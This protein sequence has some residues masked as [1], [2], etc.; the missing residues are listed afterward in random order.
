MKVK[1]LFVATAIAA[2]ISTSAFA[3]PS[4]G[5]GNLGSLPPSASFANTVAGAFTDIW[6]FNLGVPSV[7]AAS[8]TNVEVS[9]GGPGFGGIMGFSALLNGIPLVGPTSTVTVGGITVKTQVLA[10]DR[11]SV[12]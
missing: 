7:V 12:V 11:K 10:G 1:S 3:T 9:F 2:A 8:L 6:T 5:G 4:S